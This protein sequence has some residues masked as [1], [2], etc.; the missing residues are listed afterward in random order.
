MLVTGCGD[1]QNEP[2]SGGSEMQEPAGPLDATDPLQTFVPLPFH[3]VLFPYGFPVHI[4]ANHPG[5]IRAAELSWAGFRQRFRETPIEVRFLVSDFPSR[6]KPSSP[7]FRAQAN[8]LM[9]VADQHN[10]GCCDLAAGFGFAC[11]TKAAVFNMDYLRYNYLEAMVYTLLDTRHLVAMHAACVAFHDCGFLFVGES[12]AG[13][14]SLAY[15][16]ARRGW[17]YV[18]DDASCIAR[19][20]SGRSVLGNPGTFRFRPKASN[21][22]PELQGQIKLRNNKPTLEVRTECLE[23]IHTANEVVVNHLVFL[24]RSE[25]AVDVPHITAISREFALKR[26]LQQIWPTELAIHEE[27]LQA[28]ERL[29]EAEIYELTYGKFDPAIDLLEHL[30]LRSVE[31]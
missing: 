17:T 2:H 20:R 15:A 13:K 7:S 30:I 24:N 23:N 21:L 3:H 9:M 25:A 16:C 5:V 8:L 1:H 12:G 10:F 27:R 19:R 6:R 14:S 28:I 31:Q 22:F 29:L 26:L 18:S 11:V 4:K